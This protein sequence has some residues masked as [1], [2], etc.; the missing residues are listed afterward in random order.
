M[1]ASSTTP[2]KFE[3]VADAGESYVFIKGGD[4]PVYS[5]GMVTGVEV[6]EKNDYVKTVKIHYALELPADYDKTAK[7]RTAETIVSDAAIELSVKKGQ[8][9]VDLA[10][11]IDNKSKKPPFE[12]VLQDRCDK[13]CQHRRHSF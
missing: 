9:W 10:Y 1:H 7:K 12:G 3:D 2:V 5:D 8:K 4:Q 11:T 6:T 13:Q